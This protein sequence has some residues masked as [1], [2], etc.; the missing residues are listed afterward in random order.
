MGFILISD[1]VHE[2]TNP[3]LRDANSLQLLF[4]RITIQSAEGCDVIT[5]LGFDRT[6]NA[7]LFS[8]FFLIAIK[9]E[10]TA[11][12]ASSIMEVVNDITLKVLMIKNVLGTEA[13]ALLR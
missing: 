5:S 3:Q 8:Y 7:K 10:P 1:F 12:S 11:H 2:G 4:N 13:R 6:I 9:I